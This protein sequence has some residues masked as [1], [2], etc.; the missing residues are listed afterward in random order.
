MVN[1]RQLRRYE[2]DCLTFPE[3]LT[4]GMSAMGRFLISIWVA[5]DMVDGTCIHGEQFVLL[6]VSM[7][8]STNRFTVCDWKVRHKH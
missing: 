2:D 5:E 7:L 4:Q 1:V 8:K 6:C 3:N